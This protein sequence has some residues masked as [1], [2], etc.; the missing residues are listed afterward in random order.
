[1]NM[2][3]T[4]QHGFMPRSCLH[5]SGDVERVRFFIDGGRNGLDKRRALFYLAQSVLV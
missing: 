4:Q 5:H 2:Q 3:L 1:M